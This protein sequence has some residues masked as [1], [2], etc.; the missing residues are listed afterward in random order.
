[1]RLQLRALAFLFATLLAAGPAAAQTETGR[2]SGTVTDDQ[3][4]VLPGASVSLK[5]VGAGTTRATVTDTNGAFL[6]ANVAPT[7]YEVTVELQG[8]R[9]WTTK[10]VVPVGSAANVNARLAVG[11]VSEVITVRPTGP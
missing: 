10:V 1:M 5:N 8:F 3:G 7:T 6:F 11:G 2:V 9:S 4:G